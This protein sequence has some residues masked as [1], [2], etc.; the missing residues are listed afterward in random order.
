MTVIDNVALMKNKRI[1]GTSQDPEI[2][3]KIN[4]RDKVF[5]KFKNI[6]CMLIKMGRKQRMICKK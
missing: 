1:K 4:E 5:K 2:I 6:A 3:E